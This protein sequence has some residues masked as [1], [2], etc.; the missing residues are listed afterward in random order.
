MKPGRLAFRALIASIFVFLLGPLLMIVWAVLL[1]TMMLLT[2]Y[3]ETNCTYTHVFFRTFLPR[4]LLGT[5]VM[6]FA[7][8]RLAIDSPLFLQ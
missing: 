7:A 2:H 4:I 8:I 3:C 1:A 6:A 5:A